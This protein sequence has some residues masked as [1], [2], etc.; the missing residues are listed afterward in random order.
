MKSGQDA[1][2][3]RRPCAASRGPAARSARHPGCGRPARAGPRAA[4]S[5]PSGPV[6]LPRAPRR[7]GAFLSSTFTG[8]SSA[9][10]A[11]LAGQRREHRLIEPGLPQLRRQPGTGL[12]HPARPRPARPAAWR[13]PARPARAAH[14][15]TRTAPPPRRSAPARRTPSPG[16]RPA[17]ARANVTVPQHGHA[18]R[19]SAHSV[20]YR[21]IST[22]MTCAHHEPA[23]LRAVQ[24]SPAAAALRRRRPLPSSHPGSGSRARPLPGCPGWPPRLR[25]LR[26]SRS[27]SCRCPAARPCAAPSPRSVLRR[28]RPGVGA[29]LAQPAFQ[30]RDPQLQ[31]PVPLQR[32]L[33][34]SPQ[35]R[36]LG[37]LRLDHGPQPGQQLTLLPGTSRRIRHIGHKPRSC[38]TSTTGSSTPHDVSR[39]P[40]PHPVNGHKRWPVHERIEL[41]HLTA[42][43]LA[44]QKLDHHAHRLPAPA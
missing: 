3:D 41:P 31:P 24:G 20:T 7:C 10:S 5:L 25:S 16:A 17:A 9:A 6:L 18:S 13:S 26:R 38:S 1:R 15:R 4:F 29:V 28:R 34:L 11:V 23:A 19:G 22:S 40:H 12:I 30:L 36:V 44:F 35:H 37:V 21:M 42:S 33:Q 8:V 14:S 39:R 43:D 32:S 27:D 2:G